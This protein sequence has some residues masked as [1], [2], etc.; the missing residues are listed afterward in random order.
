[1]AECVKKLEDLSLEN[2]AYQLEE[3]ELKKH[4]EYRAAFEKAVK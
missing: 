1:M 2:L 3:R 4:P